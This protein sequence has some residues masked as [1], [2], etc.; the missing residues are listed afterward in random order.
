M[1]PWPVLLSDEGIEY[2]EKGRNLYIQCPWCGYEDPSKHLGI[3]LD[4]KGWGCWRNSQHRGRSPARLLFKLLGEKARKYLPDP[5]TAL[6]GPLDTLNYLPSRFSFHHVLEAEVAVDTTAWEDAFALT[7]RVTSTA[8]PLVLDYLNGRQLSNSTIQREGL[9]YARHGAL[10]WRVLCPI[11]WGQLVGWTAR[12]I[13]A[14]VKPRYI[15]GPGKL[16]SCNILREERGVGIP[17]VVVEGYFDGL[18][19]IQCD[20]SHA[21]SVVATHGTALSANKADQLKTLADRS[22]LIFAFDADAELTAV[23]YALQF[24]GCAAPMPPNRKDLG[25]CPDDEIQQWVA[26]WIHQDLINS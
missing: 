22:K 21:F 11:R 25:E 13:G 18:R 5:A 6:F 12:A 2:A 15:T 1:P 17:T 23:E 16:D 8:P 10:A 26:T 14:S 4:G 19:L 9:R 24:D 20:S 3:S 7:Q